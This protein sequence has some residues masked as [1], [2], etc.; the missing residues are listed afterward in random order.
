MTFSSVASQTTVEGEFKA[1]VK[2]DMGVNAPT[3]IHVMQTSDQA[4][5]VWYPNGVDVEVSV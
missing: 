5:T 2:V 4:G 1:I 3:M